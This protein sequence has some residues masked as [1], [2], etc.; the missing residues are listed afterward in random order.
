[1]LLIALSCLQCLFDQNHPL[2]IHDL[3]IMP[4]INKLFFFHRKV[5]TFQIQDISIYLIKAS[6]HQGHS[7]TEKKNHLYLQ[8]SEVLHHNIYAAPNQMV[9]P[10]VKNIC[11]VG[12][13]SLLK[14]TFIYYFF[15]PK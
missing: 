1:M 13:K 6:S 5:L 15:L 9:I 2:K 11:N 10:F 4:H 12:T 3:K 7:Q 8:Y 14:V